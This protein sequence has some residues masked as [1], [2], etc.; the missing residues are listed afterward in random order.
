MTGTRTDPALQRVARLRGVRCALLTSVEDALPIE[1]ASHVDVDVDQLAALAASLFRAAVHAARAAG[2]GAVHRLLVDASDGRLAVEGQ[3]GL[4]VVALAE[5]E[6]QPG[7]LRLSLQRALT[8]V[9][10]RST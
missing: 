5:R 2:H 7:P 1:S 3:M 9:T 8:D 4:L 10:Q 6:T